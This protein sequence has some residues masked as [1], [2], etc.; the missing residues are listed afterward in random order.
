[1]RGQLRGVR[2]AAF[3]SIIPEDQDGIYRGSETD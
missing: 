2:H 3:V 1:M